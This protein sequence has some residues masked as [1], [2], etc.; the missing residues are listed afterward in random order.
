[1]KAE[2]ANKKPVGAANDALGTEHGEV[3]FMRLR[4]FA[5][6]GKEAVYLA[7]SPKDGCLQKNYGKTP[8]VS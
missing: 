7:L 2:K 5:F 8:N 3:Y 6:F 4:R 1:M